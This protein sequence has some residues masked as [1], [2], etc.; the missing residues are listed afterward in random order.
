MLQND[1]VNFR[2]MCTIFYIPLGHVTMSK[3]IFVILAQITKHGLWFSFQ[4]WHYENINKARQVYLNSRRT[5]VSTNELVNNLVRLVFCRFGNTCYLF[6]NK[7]THFMPLIILTIAAS[8][9]E[10]NALVTRRNGK[11]VSLWFDSLSLG[12]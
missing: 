2:I 4:C 11:Y 7:T 5:E 6:K 9:L 3:I 1:C 8:A 10:C 12:S